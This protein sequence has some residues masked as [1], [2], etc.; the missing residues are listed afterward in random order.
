M[1][2]SHGSR[3]GH[4][5]ISLLLGSAPIA[6]A[7]LDYPLSNRNQL[8]PTGWA[9][10]GAFSI[11]YI[12]TG[13]FTNQLVALRAVLPPKGG[14]D[15]GLSYSMPPGQGMEEGPLN[16]RTLAS[17]VRLEDLVGAASLSGWRTGG[18]GILSYTT[19]NQRWHLVFRYGP[20]YSALGQDFDRLHS[21]SVI[22][23]FRFGK[24][25]PAS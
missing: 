18:G 5:A 13:D 1:K 14:S 3:I 16:R 19:P 9:P 17:R 7:Q 12:N 22:W 2:T 8:A 24:H 4:I 11:R 10:R 21:F 23:Q 6:C 25:K 20:D 15:L